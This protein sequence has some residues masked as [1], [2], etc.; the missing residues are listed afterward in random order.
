MQYKSKNFFSGLSSFFK[1]NDNGDAIFFDKP[2][3]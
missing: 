2:C 1:K 3:T